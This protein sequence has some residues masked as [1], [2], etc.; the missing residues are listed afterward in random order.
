VKKFKLFKTKLVEALHEAFE[1]EHTER[2]IAFSFAFGILITSL[3]TLGLGLLLF[4]A[5]DYYVE[6]FSRL[7]IIASIIV[8]NPFSKA[9]FYLGS[10]NIGSLILKGKIAS[11][12]A[13]EIIIHLVIGS[14]FLAV[15][16]SI[17]SYFIALKAVKAY[18]ATDL[19][20]IE[21]IDEVLESKIE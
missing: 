18:R 3:P 12:Q 4:A 20:I 17:I 19:D 10:I 14:I 8:M 13:E 2:E 11:P 16:F 6:S 5:L 1:E 21:E 9:L 15:I 7:A